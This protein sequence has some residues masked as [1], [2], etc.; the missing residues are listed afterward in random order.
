M[1]RFT[2][3]TRT[4]V[5]MAGVV[6]LSVPL[7]GGTRSS[8]TTVADAA[9]TGN[10][11]AVRTLLRD[12]NDVNAAQ[13]D[14]MTAL[15]W[16]ARQGHAAMADMLLYAGANVRATT[17]LGGYMPLHLASQAGAAPVL[18]ALVK[19]GAPVNAVT[20]TGAT[21]LMLA[22]ASGSVEAVTALADNGAEL[23]IVDTANGVTALMFA[24]AQNRTDVVQALLARG[25]DWRV[26]AKV[27]DLAA[28]GERTVKIDCD[29]LQADGGTRTA[30]ITGGYIAL[31]LALRRAVTKKI[32]PALPLRDSVAAVSAGICGGV[33]LLDL[34]YAEDA[35]AETDMNV[36]MTGR[37]D[38]VEV[39]GTAEGAPFTRA[40][41]DAMLE[42]T[43]KGIGELTV[44]QN[45]VL[46]AAP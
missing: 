23:D 25:A 3:L 29:V 31:G 42:L 44:I 16:A 8:A 43:R 32:L 22:A 34:N 30:S 7:H 26:T 28:L 24:A 40:Q 10:A 6:C 5:V 17:R 37:G 45:S 14:G 1:M 41:M 35:S 21:P 9:M 36:V 18:A 19:A 12:G 4:V 33:P 13:G 46:E 11:E 39:Q 27:V 15:H 20:T 2:P 38:L